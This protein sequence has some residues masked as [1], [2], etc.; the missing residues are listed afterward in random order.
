MAENLSESAF[1][2]LA[3]SVLAALEDGIGA[4]AE[5]QSGI[6]TVI[7]ELEGGEE[8][9][10]IVNKHAPTR[11]I[12]LSSP[13]SGARHFA[14]DGKAWNDTRGKGELLATLSAELGVVLTSAP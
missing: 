8:G 3:D 5:L 9:T 1:H 12:W 13:R 4:D 14:W 6:L 10:W 11:Q 7:K 2:S